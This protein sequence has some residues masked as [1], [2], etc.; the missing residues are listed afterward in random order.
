MSTADDDHSDHPP[1][2]D[3]ESGDDGTD[4]IVHV[5]YATLYFAADQWTI[6][7]FGDSHASD[8][9]NIHFHVP[10][11]VDF[12]IDYDEHVVTIRHPA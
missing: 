2:S 9:G 1:D 11:G 4:Y 10:P 8:D 7:Y 6:D 12:D 3:D 5:N